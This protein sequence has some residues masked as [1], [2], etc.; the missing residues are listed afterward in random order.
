MALT[1]V[2]GCG[3]IQGTATSPGQVG[4]GAAVVEPELAARYGEAPDPEPDGVTYQPDVVVVGGGAAT[5]RSV[6]ADG[7]FWTLDGAADGIDRLAVGKVMFLTSRGVGRVASIERRGGDVVVALGPVQFTDVIRDG[8]FALETPIAL[9]DVDVTQIPDSPGAL[10]EPTT[11]DLDAPRMGMTPLAG[12]RAA[13]ALPW[14]LPGKGGADVALGAWTVSTSVDKKGVTTSLTHKFNDNLKLGAEITL[15][16][17][18]LKVLTHVAV[19]GGMMTSP[20]MVIQGLEHLSLAIS[21]GA[22]NGADDNKR[23]RVE[24][25]A[26]IVNRPFVVGGVP[27]VFNLKVKVFAETAL[28]GKNTT[29]TANGKWG[30]DGDLGVRDGS[31][32]VPGFS[33]VSS[34]LDSISGIALAPSGVIVGSEVRFQLGLGVPGVVAGPY[35]KFK[36]SAGVTNG[37][38]LGAPLAKCMRADLVI[39]GGGGVGIAVDSPLLTAISDRLPGKP[40]VKLDVSAER[41]GDI[42]VRSQTI[43]DVPLCRG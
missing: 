32:V 31:V 27:L 38:A 8:T 6:S 15:G 42:A 37:S 10:A 11:E 39:K 13:D 26:E 16:T 29:L 21:A 7:L 33:V 18:E 9:D 24:V 2:T 36:F 34:I 1:L 28:G 4:G 35:G 23:V 12:A 22:A 25:P 5:V 30:L 40:K 41:M 14:P 20:T 43:P 3:A 19:A 17:R